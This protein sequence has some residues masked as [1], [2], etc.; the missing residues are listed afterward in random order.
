MCLA[1]IGGGIVIGSDDYLFVF[2]LGIATLGNRQLAFG[3]G[4]R[5]VV[6]ICALI[7]RVGEGILA[8]AH[9]GLSAGNVVGCAFALHKAFATYSDF[10]LRQR[11]AIVNLAVGRRC[12]GDSTL[13]D[14]QLAGLVLDLVAASHILACGVDDLGIAGNQFARVLACVHFAATDLHRLDSIAFRQVHACV[15]IAILCTMCLAVIGGG[16]V[17]GSDDYLFVFLLG[18]ATLGNRQLAFGRGDRVVVSICALIQRVGEGILALAHLGLSAGNVVGCAFALCKAVLAA[19]SDITVGQ[20]STIVHLAITCRSQGDFTLSDRQLAG[21][22]TRNNVLSGC[23][24][25]ANRSFRE[26]SRIGVSVGAGGANSDCTEVCAFRSAGEAGNTLF[27][28]IVGFRFTVGGELYILV[29]VESDF[30]GSDSNVDLFFLFAIDRSVAR[31]NC[32]NNFLGYFLTIGFV[33]NDLILMNLL[34]RT[35][36]IVMHRVAQVIALCPCAGEGHILGRH[37]KL[38][39]LVYLYIAACPA[40]EGIAIHR[41]LS[42]Y[43]HFRVI[44]CHSATGK[45]RCICRGFAIIL[46]LNLKFAL[47]PLSLVGNTT[48]YSCTPSGAPTCEFVAFANGILSYTINGKSRSCHTLIKACIR[49]VC[50]YILAVHAIGVDYGVGRSWDILG[51]EGCILRQRLSEICRL[52][53]LVIRIPAGEN[54]LDVFYHLII[55]RVLSLEH[56]CRISGNFLARLVAISFSANLCKHRFSCILQHITHRASSAAHDLNQTVQM[57]IGFGSI[58]PGDLIRDHPDAFNIIIPDCNAILFVKII[59]II[60]SDNAPYRPIFNRVNS[61]FADISIAVARP[62]DGAIRRVMLAIEIDL[63]VFFAFCPVWNYH[64]CVA[65]RRCVV[66][67]LAGSRCPH[68]GIVGVLIGVRIDLTENCRIA[69]HLCFRRSKQA[70][71]AHHLILRILLVQLVLLTGF[72]ERCSISLVRCHIGIVGGPASEFVGHITVGLFNRVFGGLCVFH[73]IFT[74]AL[75]KCF[76]KDRF[77]LALPSYGKLGFAFGLLTFGVFG[78]VRDTVFRRVSRRLLRLRLFI[79]RRGS[80]LIRHGGTGLRLLSLIGLGLIGFILSGLSLIVLSLL[81]LSLF[82][83]RQHSLGLS[84]LILVDIHLCDI[85]FFALVVVAL[86]L[87]GFRDAWGVLFINEIIGQNAGGEH[88]KH[89]GNGKDHCNDSFFH[90]FFLLFF[91][92]FSTLAGG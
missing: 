89:H 70:C 80:G 11:S 33:G 1:V 54:V 34:S 3:R 77:A 57:H 16:I 84:F 43:R 82:V 68:V 79:V 59:L 50:K 76:G 23:I 46:I 73:L 75:G 17:I 63:K 61:I 81:R 91:Q 64:R 29:I 40:G 31:V 60:F 52:R 58:V 28:A 13:V 39:V 53:A 37:G 47:L 14:R 85:S 22:G 78:S 24:K 42:L 32:N 87:C 69:R 88:G 56:Y 48:A 90:R 6:S 41:G 25:G 19:Y 10:I 51:I 18:I 62:S 67:P 26:V 72:L 44:G 20:R 4:D 86:A 30:I 8:L 38:A 36:P 65:Q 12:Q 45:R 7:Q 9:L 21:L 27:C 83:F 92:I 5:V 49:L 74:G 66:R 2:L 55:R 71:N 15:R 35:I